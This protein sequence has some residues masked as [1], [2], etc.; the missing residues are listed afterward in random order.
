MTIS[1]VL[2]YVSCTV[3]TEG[4][5]VAGLNLTADRCFI[6]SHPQVSLHTLTMENWEC[7]RQWLE[8]QKPGHDA[9]SLNIIAG[10][11]VGDIPICSLVIGLNKKLLKENSNGS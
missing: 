9:S 5:F 11:F 2:D 6:A 1:L 8:D 4:F 7:L 3:C 10:D